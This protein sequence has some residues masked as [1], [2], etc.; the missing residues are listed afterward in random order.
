MAIKQIPLSQLEANP[1]QTLN[2]CCDSGQ[3]LVVE[4]PDHRLIS[5]QS[6]EPDQDD[7]L[8]DEL[9]ASNPSFRDILER[10]KSGPRKPFPAT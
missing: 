3:S 2:D 4:L 7:P 6:L 9:L 10:S 1:R 8:I 5:I